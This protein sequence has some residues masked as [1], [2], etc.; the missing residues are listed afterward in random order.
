MDYKKLGIKEL[1]AAAVTR[2]MTA[3]AVKAA[4]KAELV[5]FLSAATISHVPAEPEAAEEAEQNALSLFSGAGGD[6]CGLEAAGWKVTHFSEYN[7]PAI[8]TH[9]AAHPDSE[10]LTGPEESTDIKKVADETFAALRGGVD[11]I[12][13]GHPCQGFSHAGKKRADDP[14]NELVHEFVRAARLIQ[15]TWII[16]ENVKGL[17]S[18]KGV[19][20]AN[21][22]PRPV[23]SIIRE[24]FEAEGYKL[25][26]RIVDAT[27]VGVP[28]L[29]KRL[30]YVG[31]RG[32]DYPHLPW[33][34][35]PTPAVKPT[36]R[37]ILTPT[38]V[39][40]VELPALY[41]PAEQPARFW[42]ATKETAPTG[43]P[44][45]NLLRLVGG[46]RNLSTKEKTELGH[47]K[48]E[49]VPHIEPDGL[50]SF[51]TRSSSY[52]GQVLD[53]DAPSKTIIC[54]YNQCP[55]L[56]VG[57]YNAVINKYWIRCLTPAECA[58]IQGFPADYA[59]VGS[60]KDKIV[61]IG[62][63]VPPPLATAIARL[64]AEAEFKSTPQ[65]CETPAATADS[66]S[67]E[68]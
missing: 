64:I 59:W 61:Q 66:E 25:T 63:A 46:Y 34:R 67:D 40:A 30:I 33:E 38:L 22:A 23:I 65:F 24:L 39:G 11:L 27:E 44:H 10:L 13:A 51:G 3:D 1:R 4:K 68:E 32:T 55:R 28:Q 18:R 45:P 43:T 56:F 15:P 54:A 48:T 17:L 47:A 31:H 16:G 29:R 12:F 50:I 60:T 35:L 2:G 57:L 53:P 20:P 37:A 19:Y 52:H 62:N 8:A 14:R 36:I 49:T 9:K 6:T 41:R 42:I 7:A 58:G 26:Y 21:T 5:A